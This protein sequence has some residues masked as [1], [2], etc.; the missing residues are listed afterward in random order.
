MSDQLQEYIKQTTFIQ[1]TPQEV[2]DAI[3]STEVWNAFFTHNSTLDPST[4][5]PSFA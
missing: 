5:G 1:Q 2:F 3:T 4:G